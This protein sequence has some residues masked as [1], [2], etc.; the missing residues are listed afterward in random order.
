MIPSVVLSQ[1]ESK[2]EDIT[3]S[4]SLINLHACE[5]KPEKEM[6][7]NLEKFNQSHFGRN[8]TNSRKVMNKGNA[9]LMSKIEEQRQ[10][11][12]LKCG[13]DQMRR[14]EIFIR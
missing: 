11:G 4:L 12:I 5:N 6:E 10:F 2:K 8:W 3:C 7:G 14:K 13:D 1:M 9:R